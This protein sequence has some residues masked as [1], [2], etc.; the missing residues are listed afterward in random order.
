MS[1]GYERSERVRIRQLDL[2]VGG[3]GGDVVGGIIQGAG[4][5]G[6]FMAGGAND[7]ICTR[8]VYG[9]GT[10]STGHWSFD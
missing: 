10:M 2:G 4:D 3:A 6:V 8:R 9:E 7:Y 1:R 5:S